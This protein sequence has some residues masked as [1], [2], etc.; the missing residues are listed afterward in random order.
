MNTWCVYM[1]ENRA[2]GKKYIG[3]TKQA[4]ERRWQNGYGYRESPRFYKAIEK[5]GWDGFKHEILYT[6]LTA[7]EAA[8]KEVELIA[9]YQTT[10]PERGYNLDPGGGG[11]QPKTE[12]VRAKMS[13]ARL[14]THPTAATRERLR[15]SHTGLKQTP[16][17]RKKRSE[18]LLGKKKSEEHA[19]N[20]GRAKSKPVGMYNEAGEKIAVFSSMTAAGLAT[21]INFKNISEVC[22]GRRHKAGGYAWKFMD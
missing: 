13:R 3:I 6:H 15:A 8:A 9:K 1:H 20:I 21:G 5:Y 12:E 4:P 7:E 2:N 16:E 19:Q 14:G 11:T 17:T 22:Y 18:A 10:D